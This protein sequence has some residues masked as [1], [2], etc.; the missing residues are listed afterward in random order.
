MFLKKILPIILIVIGLALIAVPFYGKYKIKENMKNATIS[1]AEVKPEQLKQNDERVIPQEHFDFEKIDEISP[2]S[3]FLSSGNIDKSLLIGQIVV[4]SVNMNL[5]IFKGAT[6]DNLLA[7]VATMK[8]EDKMG[9]QNFTLAGHY[10]KDKS[11]LFGALMDVKVDDIVRVTDKTY[12]YEYKIYDTRVV[13]D[14]ALYMI[15]NE[16]SVKRG[17]AIISLMT[18]YHSS[19]T[20]K[21]Y[22]ALGDLVQV[23]PYSQ[24]LMNMSLPKKE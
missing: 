20:G 19:K 16:E 7:G 22:F 8:M 15:E 3:T 18:C 1:I 24:E 12:I 13:D 17:N 6:N 5:S 11:I 2:T 21:R 4:P 9:E 23:Y 14:T 10:N